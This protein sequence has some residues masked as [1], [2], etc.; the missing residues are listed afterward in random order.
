M[1]VGLRRLGIASQFN[2]EKLCALDKAY[3]RKNGNG[4]R[5]GAIE[6]KQTGLF[7]VKI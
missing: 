7:D 3:V 6:E 2:G 4:I 5:G 1:K